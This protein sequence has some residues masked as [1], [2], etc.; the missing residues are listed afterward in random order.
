[1]KK[2]KKGDPAKHEREGIEQ[3]LGRGS[4]GVISC[5][6]FLKKF[7]K[8]SCVKHQLEGIRHYRK[9]RSRFEVVKC[10]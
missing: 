7:F 2:F 9:A 3:R 4:L 8:G 10:K 1:M 5:K 6:N